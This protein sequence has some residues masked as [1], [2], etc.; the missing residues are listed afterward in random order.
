M[1][2]ST[3]PVPA[4]LALGASREAGLPA[5]GLGNNTSSLLR[6]LLTDPEAVLY[7]GPVV[8]IC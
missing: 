8:I 4:I 6:K 2:R 5:S 1:A 7:L 3:N